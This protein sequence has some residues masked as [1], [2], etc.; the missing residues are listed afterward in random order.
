MGKAIITITDSEDGEGVSMSYD[1]EPAID[2][3]GN[4][5]PLPCQIMAMRIMQASPSLV[6][7]E[8]LSTELE[9]D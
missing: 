8:T 3:T 7:G 4:A 9:G 1:F 2:N 6:N 5:T